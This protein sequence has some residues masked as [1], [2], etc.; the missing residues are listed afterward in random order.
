MQ[1]DE[2]PNVK[3]FRF[4]CLGTSWG[5]GT[6]LFGILQLHRKLNVQ[7]FEFLRKNQNS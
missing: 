2:K 7:K 6:F 1:Y 4:S 3:N 5:V